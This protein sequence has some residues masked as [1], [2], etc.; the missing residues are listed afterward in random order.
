MIELDNENNIKKFIPDEDGTHYF[1]R[2][3]EGTILIQGVANSN[4]TILTKLQY[5]IVFGTSKL[6][7]IPAI[8]ENLGPQEA[9]NQDITESRDGFFWGDG[10]PDM[11]KEVFFVYA[12]RSVAEPLS[13]ALYGVVNP[14]EDGLYAKVYDHEDE[15]KYSVLKF[16]TTDTIPISLSADPTPLQDALAVTVTDGALTQEEVDNI[17]NAVTYYAGQEINLTDFIPASW[18]DKVITEEEAISQGYNL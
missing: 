5:E 13:R 17:V 2:N 1:I 18:K 8:E 14:N 4:E 11:D 3:E 7:I 6:D 9:F 16:Q 12:A 10:I 15:N